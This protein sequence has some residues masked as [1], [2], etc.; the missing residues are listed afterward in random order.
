MER[1]REGG[2]LERLGSL[3][4]LHPEQIFIILSGK[5]C[6]QEGELSSLRHPAPL[7]EEEEEDW[8]KGREET[9]P[10]H[11]S[12]SCGMEAPPLYANLLLPKIAKVCHFHS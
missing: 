6:P 3:L 1:A 4:S 10:Y 7:Q 5:P 8:E 12:S 9:H 11:I 2:G